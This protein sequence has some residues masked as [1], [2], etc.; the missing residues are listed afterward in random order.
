MFIVA[1]VIAAKKWKQSN[2][3]STG[4]QSN[5]LYNINPV[6]EWPI[7]TGNS[8]DERN[9]TKKLY[10]YILYDSIYMQ[11]EKKQIYSDKKQ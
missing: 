2:C 4:K 3:S 7:D 10:V 9:Q 1:L 8:I 5:I 6:E 11:F